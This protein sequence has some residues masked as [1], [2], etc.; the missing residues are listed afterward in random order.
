MTIT[1]QPSPPCPPAPPTQHRSWL[2]RGRP[3][4]GPA[5]GAGGGLLPSLYHTPRWVTLLSVA[6]AGTCFGWLYPNK[7]LAAPWGFVQSAMGWTYTAAWSLSFYP[8][9][10]ERGEVSLLGALVQSVALIGLP[11]SEL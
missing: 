8:Q 6:V 7:G 3:C 11:C 1:R 4:C 10:R 2:G 9:V 5:G